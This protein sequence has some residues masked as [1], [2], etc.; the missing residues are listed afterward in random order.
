MC[1][2]ALFN[3]RRI[4][5]SVCS[6]IWDG[7]ETWRR[8]QCK[9]GIEIA[10]YQEGSNRYRR[11]DFCYDCHTTTAT[12][13]PPPAVTNLAV[14]DPTPGRLIITIIDMAH[15]TLTFLQAVFKS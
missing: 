14:S 6:P 15:E 9:T 7:H 10:V 1:T 4:P 2:C 13:P 12:P 3:V 8:R 5:H 11:S